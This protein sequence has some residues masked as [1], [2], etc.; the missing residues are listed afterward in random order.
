VDAIK[1]FLLTVLFLKSGGKLQ[2]LEGRYPS[3]QDGLQ[4]T[5]VAEAVQTSIREHRLVQIAEIS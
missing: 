2:Q 4:V 1:D 5:R 3:G